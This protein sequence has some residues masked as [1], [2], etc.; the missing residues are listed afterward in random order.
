MS[1]KPERSISNWIHSNVERA[2]RN[3]FQVNG[4]RSALL[5]ELPQ[6]YHRASRSVN[7][8]ETKMDSTQGMDCYNIKYLFI[9]VVYE[10]EGTGDGQYVAG[11]VSR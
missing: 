10:D 9:K 1:M 5:L 3:L 2:G 7:G 6:Y 11:M 4:H 8:C